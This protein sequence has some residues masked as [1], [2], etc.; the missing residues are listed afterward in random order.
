MVLWTRTKTGD[1]RE[2]I[3][4]QILPDKDHLRLV[5]DPN[6]FREP[7][8]QT[9][10]QIRGIVPADNRVFSINVRRAR[11]RKPSEQTTLE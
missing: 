8:W 2:W 11:L 9:F 7:G 4:Q 6:R 10:F 5:F 1:E 3:R